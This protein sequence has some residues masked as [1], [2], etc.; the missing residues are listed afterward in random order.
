[1]NLYNLYNIFNSLSEAESELE[2][3]YL[4][5]RALVLATTS[6]VSIKTILDKNL[7]IEDSEG[8]L[9]LDRYISD[10]DITVE[11]PSV[12]ELAKSN[13]YKDQIYKF[14]DKFVYRRG[15][16]DKSRDSILINDTSLLRR[17]A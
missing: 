5:Q 4:Y 6:D 8:S 13:K 10:N 16:T 2:Y 1:M 11:F 3:D 17:A 7:H 9:P 14:G 15:H 12:Y